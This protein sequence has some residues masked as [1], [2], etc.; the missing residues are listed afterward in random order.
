MSTGFIRNGLYRSWLLV[1]LLTLA[2]C[3]PM[4][5]RGRDMPLSVQQY[6]QTGH[7]QLAK[8]QLREAA[9]TIDRME[10][11]YPL[12]AETSRMQ[13]ELIEAYYD[14]AQMDQTVALAG[15]FITMFPGHKDVDYAYYLRGMANFARGI[16]A[17]SMMSAAP[18][19]VYARESQAGLAQL[20]ERFPRSQYATSAQHY[21]NYLQGQIEL[22]EFR[23]RGEFPVR[24]VAR[25]EPE[26]EPE[27]V[28]PA[29]AVVIPA[30]R[31]ELQVEEKSPEAAIEVTAPAV[32]MTPP[33]PPPVAVVPSPVA[34]PVAAQPRD[35]P[36]HTLQVAAFDD[37]AGLKR[38]IARLGLGDEV[39]YF[40]REVKGKRIYAALY[41]RYPS[42]AAARARAAELQGRAGLKDLWLRQRF[43]FE[44]EVEA[45]AAR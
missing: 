32:V 24:V 10:L 8:K 29:T 38:H 5:D 40:T 28:K 30:A 4:P 34:V 20:L 16:T 36:F 12:H 15:R 11:L 44:T 18:D 1:M 14:A 9:A 2:A 25:P 17:L 31:A 43:S 21:A 41:G 26:P 19:A 6:Y 35:E 13:L 7:A 27:P 37:L 45:A 22:F 42:A 23:Q 39:R 33:A 3:A